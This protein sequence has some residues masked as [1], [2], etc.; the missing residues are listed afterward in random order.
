[1]LLQT[2]LFFTSALIYCSSYSYPGFLINSFCLS[3]FSFNVVTSVCY[4]GTDNI[5]LLYIVEFLIVTCA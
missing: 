5:A 2:L 1:M 4:H 3:F